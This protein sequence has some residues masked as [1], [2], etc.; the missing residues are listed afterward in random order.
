MVTLLAV[1]LVTLVL[2]LA[3]RFANRHHQHYNTLLLPVLALA[4]G[5]ASWVIV[6]FTGLGYNPDL[7][8]LSWLL[9]I[10]ASTVITIG[11]AWW[12]GQHREASEAAALRR[13]SDD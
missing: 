12:L 2:G 6:Q 9:P 7:F 8:W 13:V 1:T 11:V 3:V 5:L 10:I 4:S